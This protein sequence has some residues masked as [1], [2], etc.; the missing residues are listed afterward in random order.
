MS[1]AI[2]ILAKT[3]RPIRQRPAV[4]RDERSIYF[5]QIDDDGIDLMLVS[6]FR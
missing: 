1:G 4:S 3:D 2:R 5:T 6:D